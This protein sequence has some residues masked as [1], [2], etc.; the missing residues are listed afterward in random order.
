MELLPEGS[1][2]LFFFI[3]LKK[4][5][6]VLASDNYSHFPEI[7]STK[8]ACLSDA[9]HNVRDTVGSWHTHQ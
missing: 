5:P 3:Q 1:R 2:A 7:P 9:F 6:S 8:A 4:T